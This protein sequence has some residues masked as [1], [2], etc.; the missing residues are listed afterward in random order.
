MRENRR[1]LK[2]LWGKRVL[3]SFEQ[4]GGGNLQR[5]VE[6][7]MHLLVTDGVSRGLGGGS[8]SLESGGDGVRPGDV[9]TILG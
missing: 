8:G 4:E 3:I 7:W 6:D 2:G 9:R 5:K 1:H